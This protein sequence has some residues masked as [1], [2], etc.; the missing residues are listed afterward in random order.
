[1]I[2]SENAKKL[3]IFFFYDKDGI[4][5]AYIPV[6]LSDIRKNLDR[7]LVVCNG[8][9]TNESMADL[10]RCC[11]DV[12]VRPNKGFDVWAYKTAIEYLSWDVVK[13]YDELVLFN[14]T[15]FGPIYP[16]KEMFDAMDAKDVDFWGPTV[17]TGLSTDPFGKIE[18]GYIPMHIQSHFIAVRQ[19]MLNS[20]AFFDHWNNMCEIKTYNDSVCYH[21]A[22]F[23]KKFADKGYKW[24]SYIDTSDYDIDYTGYPLMMMPTEL[25]KN[26]RCPIIK[27]KSFF[28]EIEGFLYEG[29]GEQSYE[30]F[31][32]IRD[33]TDYDTEL[34]LKNILRTCNQYDIRNALQLNY[35]LPHEALL[36]NDTQA[37]PKV[38]L[39][40]HICHDDMIDYCFEYAKSMPRY[41][42]VYVVTDGAHKK[43]KILDVFSPLEC[44]KLQVEQ[45]EKNNGNMATLIVTAADYIMDYDYVC[46]AHDRKET[47][48]E[49]QIVGKS[50]AYLG[51]ESVLKTPE[52]VTNV[53]STFGNNPSLGMLCSSNPVFSDY[54]KGIGYEWGADYDACVELAKNLALNV[55]M[56]IKKAPITPV[57]SYFWFRPKALKPIY[58]Y[59][60]T[61]DD[62]CTKETHID[63]KLSQSGAMSRVAEKLLPI[64]AQ[65]QGF[66]SAWVMPG[67]IAAMQLTTFVTRNANLNKATPDNSKYASINYDLQLYNVRSYNETIMKYHE[68]VEQLHREMKWFSTQWK[69]SREDILW[70]QQR[71]EHESKVNEAVL[72]IQNDGALD[73]YKD[74]PPFT[75][76]LRTHMPVGVRLKLLMRVLMPTKLYNALRKGK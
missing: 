58:D 21:E 31:N 60:F 54:Y 56:N 48:I 1:M 41:A 35:V 44:N 45:I 40:L 4:V 6:M 11:D 51:F 30:L 42:D 67:N 32:Y 73:R 50:V 49:P 33:F 10:K 71:L 20:D 3:G 9:I 52:Y 76:V 63:L 47:A 18:I 23:T 65:A 39:L 7:L 53:I 64:T 16:F 27:R 69:A 29:M 38:A 25:V 17:Y 22:I 59:K 61:Y 72:R 15:I 43:D 12:F 66:Y 46:V 62:F 24:E 70:L 28:Y 34:I 14:F 2:L 57:N 36:Q 75:E 37:K 74:S 8:E 19:P 55:D 5:D 68:S 13:T 26:R